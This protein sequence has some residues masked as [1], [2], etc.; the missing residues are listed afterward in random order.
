MRMFPLT[1]PYCRRRRSQFSAAVLAV[2]RL[3]A[4]DGELLVGGVNCTLR[5]GLLRSRRQV[6]STTLLR[7]LLLN[8]LPTARV[9]CQGTTR[10]RNLPSNA[11][12]ALKGSKGVRVHV[13]GTV[14]REAQAEG[15][16][17]LVVV[18]AALRWCRCHGPRS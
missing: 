6:P 2:R 13:L 10:R 18:V 3:C 12:W 17:F 9:L 1:L 5:G 16:H 11:A 4:A 15:V 7:E 8:L 14:E